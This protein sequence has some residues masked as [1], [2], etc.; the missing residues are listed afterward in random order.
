MSEILRISDT[1]VIAIS[2][3]ERQYKTT[4]I[5]MEGQIRS[6]VYLV[7]DVFAHLKEKEKN[8]SVLFFRLYRKHS[9]EVELT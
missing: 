6:E 2:N 9:C 8:T 4:R 7:Q 1:D 5:I 3:T